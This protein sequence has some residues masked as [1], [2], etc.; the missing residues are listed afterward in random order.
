MTARRFS[1]N[2]SFAV[3]LLTGFLILISFFSSSNVALS[4]TFV[5]KPDY[6][7]GNDWQEKYKMS[8]SDLILDPVVINI[9][10]NRGLTNISWTEFYYNVGTI[11]MKT[12]ES[13]D[14]NIEGD[15]IYH[16]QLSD[17]PSLRCWTDIKMLSEGKPSVPTDMNYNIIDVT[18]FLKGG[19]L[20]EGLRSEKFVSF[21]RDIFWFQQKGEERDY[22]SASSSH[23]DYLC[24]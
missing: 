4:E 11:H 22:L 10:K 24:E 16:H 18:S 13:Y 8:I 19:T 21:H 6:P 9:E 12:K 15:Q 14:C 17:Y 3:I 5:C 7:D 1:L 23:L 2:N 20:L